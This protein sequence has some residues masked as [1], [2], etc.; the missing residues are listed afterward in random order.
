MT[1]N[2]VLNLQSY[3]FILELLPHHHQY[4]FDIIVPTTCESVQLLCSIVDNVESLVDEWFPGLRDLS[5]I[6]GAELITP[7]ALCPLCPGT[8]INLSQLATYISG[9]TTSLY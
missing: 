2:I 6:G 7:L 4:S 8:Y 3:Y 1:D 9:L 5:I